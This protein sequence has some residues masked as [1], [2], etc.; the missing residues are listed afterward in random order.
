MQKPQPRCFAGGAFDAVIIDDAL[1]EA[2]GTAS[3]GLGRVRGY[4]MHMGQSSGAD[5]VRPFLD[6]GDEDGGA[7][8]E[9][10]RI[11]GCY[12]H[13]LFAAD[14]FRA[15][16]LA[17]LGGHGSGLA[18]ESDVEAALDELADAMESHLNLDGLAA[19]AR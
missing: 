14:E 8:S 10:G 11:M 3:G 18:Y 5:R 2:E 1:A 13:G 9:D 12:L 16:F 19:L 7:V 4:E 6:L 17:R 15:A